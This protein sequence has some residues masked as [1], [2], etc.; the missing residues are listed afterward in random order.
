MHTCAQSCAHTLG[1]PTGH[2]AQAQTTARSGSHE[3]PH[4]HQPGP[5]L[6]NA[7]GATQWLIHTLNSSDTSHPPAQGTYTF[8]DTQKAPTPR[9]ALGHAHWPQHPSRCCTW[10]TLSTVL[11]LTQPPGEAEDWVDGLQTG[12]ALPCGQDAFSPGSSAG[13][14]RG[15]RP[16]GDL[17]PKLEG[18]G[19]WVPLAQPGGGSH[20][21]TEG[22]PTRLCHGRPA[23]T[24]PSLSRGAPG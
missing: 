15:E 2:P 10:H 5:M 9:P 21:V 8:P 16:G 13:W 17:G 11:A 24:T 19:T 3:P 7:P 20:T 1:P 12:L 4:G 18:R 22:I 14:L 6:S 23:L